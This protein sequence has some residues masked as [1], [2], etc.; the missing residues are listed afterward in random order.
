MSIR[1]N[2]IAHHTL[3]FLLSARGSSRYKKLL[4][5]DPNNIING[6]SRTTLSR[7]KENY[8]AEKDGSQ[9]KITQKGRGELERLS[10]LY[11]TSP[12]EQNSTKNTIVAFD[13][14]EN[15]RKIR[16]WIRNQLKIFDYTMLQ[17]SLWFGPGPLPKEFFDRL[18][19]LNIRENVKIFNVR[20]KRS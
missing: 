1:R 16:A 18:K 5:S 10:S 9:W 12:F 3:A 14:P 6:G 17:Q 2:S 7:L 20:P 8:Y 19:Y 11:I 13:I 15:S 4:R